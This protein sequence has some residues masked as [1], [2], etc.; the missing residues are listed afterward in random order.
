M[1]PAVAWG[2]LGSHVVAT[3][4]ARGAACCGGVVSIVR[5]FGSRNYP[6]SSKISRTE[7]EVIAPRT[8]L[9]QRA[10]VWRGG[11]L[12]VRLRVIAYGTCA[13]YF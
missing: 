9:N 11:I 3:K 10:G 5:G 6:P 4:S 7:L 8:Q 2:R 12:H 1:T 13:D